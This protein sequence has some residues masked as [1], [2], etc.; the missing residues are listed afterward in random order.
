MKGGRA[1]AREAHRVP[2]T[3]AMLDVL[4]VAAANHTD[5]DVTAQDLPLHARRFRNGLVFS[6]AEGGTYSDA[7]MSATIKRMNAD[8]PEGEPMPWRDVDGRPITQHGFRRAFRTWVDDERPEDAAAAEAQLAH[9]EPDKVK[10]AYRGGDLLTRRVPL[11]TA[12]A[13]HC[14]VGAT[15]HNV[16]VLTPADAAA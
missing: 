3:P 1:K 8:R 14:M 5:Q 9:Q 10:A 4:A 2:I 16:V 15:A 11:M 12:W 6:T 13:V 7:A